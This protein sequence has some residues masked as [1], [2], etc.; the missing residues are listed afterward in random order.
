MNLL[1][2]SATVLC[3]QSVHHGKKR[4]ILIENGVIKRIASAIANTSKQAVIAHKE[5]YICPG[6]FELFAQFS[7][8]G[9]E[10]KETIC[11]GAAAAQSGGYTGVC[12]V[13][14]TEP[15]VC[16]K[17]QVEYAISQG[18]NTGIDIMPLGAASAKIEGIALAEMLDMYASGAV[19]FTDGTAP[20]QKPSLMVKALQYVKSFDG[21]IIQVPMDMSIAKNGLMNE[22]VVSTQLGL[23]GM[24]AIAEEL[25]ISRDLSLLEY[26]QSRLHFTGVSTARGIAAIAQAK[27]K[28]LHVTCSVTPY[29]LLFTDE[30]LYHYNS[31]YKV[32][33]PL[34]LESDRKAL[35]KALAAGT[36]DAIATH[37]T[38]QDW[39]AKTIEFEYAQFGMIGLET[40]LQSLLPLLNQGIDLQM[41]I[42]V[43]GNGARACLSIPQVQIEINELADLCIFTTSGQQIYTSNRIK[44][45]SK[46]SPYLDATLSGSILG[47]VHKGKLYT[48]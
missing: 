8:P 35:V 29:H 17:A 42:Q 10:H 40:A 43:L 9:S 22:G 30:A 45:K 28:G 14:N 38:P 46:N 19:A 20:I 32:M 39:D 16:S 6:F 23:A 21:V 26:T 11:T 27:K 13:P 33:P 31:V 24:P 41:L 48:A 12:I 47:T 18:S 2:K 4:D 15:A 1:I 5:L 3:Q 44:S 25:I 7:D 34:R 36:I 37:H